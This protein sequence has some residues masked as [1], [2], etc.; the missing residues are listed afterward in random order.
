MIDSHCH[1]LDEAFNFDRDKI[2]QDSKKKLKAIVTCALS[3]DELRLS[4][5]LSEKCP[6]FIY[7]TAGI[8]PVDAAEI[9]DEEFEK[10]LSFIES[11]KDKIVGIGEIGLDYHWINDLN[12]IKKS[13]ELF[14]KLIDFAKSLNLPIVLHLRGAFEEG[15]K[16]VKSKKVKKAMFHC[17]YGKPQLAEKIIQEGYLVSIATNIV[18]NKNMKR[19]TKKLSL[20]G[21]VTETDS[22]FLSINNNRNK[23]ENVELVVQ[24]IAELRN[25]E[26]FKVDEITTQNSIKF[27]N[28]DV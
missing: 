25:E 15:F 17:F 8:H 7:V 14:I 27:F 4:L 9:S 23:P 28:L 3:L 19:I 1:I 12:K 22:P 24:K 20:S 6:K 13:K 5:K 10:F 18:R 21:I 2:I 16:I 11:N 26:F